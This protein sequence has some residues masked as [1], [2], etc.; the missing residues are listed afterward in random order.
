MLSLDPA[1]AKPD[2]SSTPGLWS[3]LGPSADQGLRKGEIQMKLRIRFK[4]GS[5]TDA[6]LQGGALAKLTEAL[7]AVGVDSLETI[8]T[9]EVGNPQH[10]IPAP[11]M[12]PATR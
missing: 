8:E 6:L 7:A 5:H 1:T 9:I 4:D 12:G 11:G 3:A 2:P 10:F